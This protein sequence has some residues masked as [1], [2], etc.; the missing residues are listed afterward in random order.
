MSSGT[1]IFAALNERAQITFN[2]AGYAALYPLASASWQFQIRPS[3]GSTTLYFDF[4]VDGS[5]T[6][7]AT[8]TPIVVFQ[9]PTSAL[10][11]IPE[12]LASYDWGF[13]LPGADYE[14]AG[15][16]S[17]D[18]AAGVTIA[19]ITGAPPAPTGSDDTWIGGANPAPTALPLSLTTAVALTAASAATTASTAAAASAAAAAVSAAEAEAAAGNSALIYALIFG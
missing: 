16:G 2:V 14:V 9:A 6:Y 13:I 18:F 3:Q 4:A 12:G 15:W 11:G 10:A 19:G 1:P 17:I 5:I 7:S 8:P